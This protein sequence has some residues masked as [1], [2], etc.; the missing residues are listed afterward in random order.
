[1]RRAWKVLPLVLSLWAG[2][3]LGAKAKV[4]LLSGLQGSGDRLAAQVRQKVDDTR[5]VDP[6]ATRFRSAG[7]RVTARIEGPET[8]VKI[9]VQGGKAS[10]IFLR[11][12]SGPIRI[13]RGNLVIAGGALV[14][15]ERLS[16]AQSERRRYARKDKQP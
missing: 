11:T 8:I 12:I 16:Y 3:A 9:P 7:G 1:M 15:H 6:K 13:E 10:Y 2:N 5:S 14:E 4:Y